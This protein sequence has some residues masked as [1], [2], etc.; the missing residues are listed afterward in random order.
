MR[1]AVRVKRSKPIDNSLTVT[2]E[3]IDL[4]SQG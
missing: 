3:M 2:I 1:D 4:H